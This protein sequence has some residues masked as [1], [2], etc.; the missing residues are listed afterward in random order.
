MTPL[1]RWSP[2]GGLALCYHLH[3]AMTLQFFINLVERKRVSPSTQLK[4]LQSHHKKPD[5][6]CFCDSYLYLWWNSFFVRVKLK[7]L[8]VPAVVKLKCVCQT[9]IFQKKSKNTLKLLYLV[10]NMLNMF[11]AVCQCVITFPSKGDYIWHADFLVV[12]KSFAAQ[13]ISRSRFYVDEHLLLIISGISC[14]S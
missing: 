9:P 8:F 2:E 14:C 10:L 7:L 5:K 12:S 1:T 11:G 4:C 13:N 6:L 3:V